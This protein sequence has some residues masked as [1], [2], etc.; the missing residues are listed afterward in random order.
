MFTRWMNRILVAVVAICASGT[1]GARADAAD[2]EI[3]SFRLTQWKAA[4]FD[5]AKT[6]KTNFETL[7]RIG[8]EAEQ[9]RHDGHFDVR[10]RCAKWRSIAL[11]SHDEAHQW[12]RWLKAY[13]FETT[14]QH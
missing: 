1:V 12:E 8:C 14:H 4:H 7:K 13:G 2:R 11:K 3:V 6:A 10:Y 9:H 5:D